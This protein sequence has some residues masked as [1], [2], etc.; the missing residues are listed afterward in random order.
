M[1]TTILIPE[2]IK[3]IK[4]PMM[5]SI[6]VAK[7]NFNLTNHSR[8]GIE[9]VENMSGFALSGRGTI[10]SELVLNYVDKRSAGV[11]P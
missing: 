3:I 4:E 2:N 1:L 8:T 10:D 7:D 9:S 6:I 11:A 5:T